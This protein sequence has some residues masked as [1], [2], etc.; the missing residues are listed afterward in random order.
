MIDAGKEFPGL[1]RIHAD[2]TSKTCAQPRRL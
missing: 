2:R 1:L